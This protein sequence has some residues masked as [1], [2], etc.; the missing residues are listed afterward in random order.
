MAETSEAGSHHGDPTL[1]KAEHSTCLQVID[2]IASY[3]QQ[4]GNLAWLPTELDEALMLMPREAGEQEF[5]TVVNMI[6]WIRIARRE[7]YAHDVSP[8]WLPHGIDL[9]KSRLFWR[10]RSGKLP[11]P[12]PPPTA[13]SCPW[14]ELIED[15]RPH[16]VHDCYVHKPGE[17]GLWGRH[18]HPTA[19][20]GNTPY[21]ILEFSDP[22]ETLP[23]IVG[24]DP[25]FLDGEIHYRFKSFQGPWETCALDPKGHTYEKKII[26][27]WWLE[28]IPEE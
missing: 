14:Y 8:N 28:Y 11:L 23:K 27:G 24:Y 21:R 5:R 12:Y 7:R 6:S 16:W 13:W 17:A 1:S 2:A 22:E 19:N 25:T 18:P 3:S 4:I 20:L 10:L 15:V 9:L 26:T